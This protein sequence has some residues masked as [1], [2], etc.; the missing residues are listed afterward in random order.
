MKN[1]SGQVRQKPGSIH[2]MLETGRPVVSLVGAVS[3]AGVAGNQMEWA[4]GR[5]KERVPTA[6]SEVWL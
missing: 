1:R 3:C 4:E 6:L 2:W 5:F